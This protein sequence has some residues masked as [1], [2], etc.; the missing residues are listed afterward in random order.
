MDT[1][2]RGPSSAVPSEC[3]MLER[4][5]AVAELSEHYQAGRL[6]LEE[7][8]DRSTQALAGPGPAATSVRCSPTCRRARRPRC[9]PRPAGW[10]LTF[11]GRSGARSGRPFTA[12]TVIACVIA[13]IIIGNVAGGFAHTCS[14]GRGWLML[15]VVSASS[16]CG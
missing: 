4:Y 9:W 15:F 2:P 11:D 6:T 14:A 13:V 8:D 10:S 12:R 5:E 3:R 16:S 7:F 1:P